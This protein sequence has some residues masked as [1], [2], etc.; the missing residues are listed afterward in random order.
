MAS[1]PMAKKAPA[2]D[3]CSV[4][5]MTA[6]DPREAPEGKGEDVGELRQASLA[7]AVERRWAAAALAML[8]SRGVLPSTLPSPTHDGDWLVH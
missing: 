4:W 1:R 3:P 6:G 8:P 2:V 7:K 5:V